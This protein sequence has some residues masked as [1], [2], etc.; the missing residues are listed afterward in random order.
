MEKNGFLSGKAFHQRRLLLK[1]KSMMV[2]DAEIKDGCTDTRIC[3]F[4]QTEAC[5][6][7]IRLHIGE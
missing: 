2:G 5:M 6:C 7:T 3:G 1:Q 4:C